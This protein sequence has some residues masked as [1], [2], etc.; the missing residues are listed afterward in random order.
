MANIALIRGAGISADRYVS[1]SDAVDRGVRTFE[2]AQQKREAE[3]EKLRLEKEREE[4]IKAKDYKSL[5]ALQT[6]GVPDAWKSWYNQEALNIKEEN[7]QL[8]NQK[9]SMNQFDYMDSLSAQQGKIGQMQNS[10]A[11]IKEYSQAYKEIS[12]GGDFSNSLTADEMG[13]IQ[14]VV[15]LNGTPVFRNGQMYFKSN[16]TGQEVSF[17]DLPEL[18][19]K[20]YE[21]HN[22]IEKDIIS[23]TENAAKN[24]M[25]IGGKDGNG[26][27]A[28]L[29]SKIDDYFRNLELQP[30]QAMSL[31]M[32]FL[33][34]GGP[35][36]ELAPTFRTLTGE[37]LIDIDG[38]GDI[39]KDD[40]IQSFKNIS[41]PKDFV[42]RVKEQYKNIAINTSKNLKPEYDRINKPK[43]AKPES[44]NKWEFDELIRQ[45][46]LRT[47]AAYLKPISK[48]LSSKPISETE[49]KLLIDYANNKIPGIEIYQNTQTDDDGALLNPNAYV[50]EVNGKQK[51]FIIGQTS[52]SAIDKFIKDLY[53]YSATD[54]LTMFGAEVDADSNTSTTKE[55]PQEKISNAG[56]KQPEMIKEG[57]YPEEYSNL[58]EE[59]IP[60]AEK[61]KIG[62][63]RIIKRINKDYQGVFSERNIAEVEYDLYGRDKENEERQ[64]NFIN[65]NKNILILENLKKEF[66]T[67]SDN[68]LSE[69]T[70][71]SFSIK[72]RKLIEEFIGKPIARIT[73]KEFIQYKYNLAGGDLANLEE[74]KYSQYKEG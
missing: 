68:R 1:I 33:K 34:M 20:D 36:G 12:E 39:D 71:N 55:T 21:T 48:F 57:E 10:I 56:L 60:A 9:G 49:A 72:E 51:P 19:T 13:L 64:K 16:T 59:P 45:K 41:L 32:D 14:D 7:R 58:S 4:L 47:T 40:Y 67:A 18:T 2:T 5:G 46:E 28:Y 42:D 70:R 43:P 35:Y 44:L 24:G 22:K 54:R 37:K 53:G 6:D 62:D 3:A 29:Q 74:D 23:I 69:K 73:E 66:E 38:D 65:E 63:Q 11:A 26:D 8:V 30:K 52:G 25:F 61:R 31:A 17:D 27:S 15:Q 50:I